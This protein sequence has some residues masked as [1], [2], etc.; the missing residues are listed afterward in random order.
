MFQQPD[1]LLTVDLDQPLYLVPG[2][3]AWRSPVVIPSTFVFKLDTGDHLGLAT[4]LPP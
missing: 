4:C 1:S 3:E 2:D